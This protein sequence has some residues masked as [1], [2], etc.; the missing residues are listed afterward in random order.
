MAA[1]EACPSPKPSYRPQEVATTFVEGYYLLLRD[2]PEELHKFYLD[3][4]TVS[5]RVG[6]DGGAMTNFTTMEEIEKQVNTSLDCKEYEIVSFYAQIAPNK[7]VFV[8]VVGC[9]T[10]KDDKMRKFNQSFLLAPME[11]IGYFVSNDILSFLDEQ[12]TIT[13][14]IKDVPKDCSEKDVPKDVPKKS[15]L[16]VVSALTENNDPFKAPPVKKSV[17]PTPQA[18][19]PERK[20]GLDGKKKARNVV[21]NVKGERSV[22]VGNLAF[23]SNPEEV[24]EA[25]KSSFGAIKQN[26]VQIRTDKLNRCYAFIQFESSESA[27]SAVQASSIRIGNRKLNI[28]EKKRNA[29]ENHKSSQDQSINGNVSAN[30]Q[31]NSRGNRN[32][33]RRNGPEN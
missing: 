29:S 10:T 23:D 20:S 9:L 19:N 30:G 24:Y 6:S 32:S 3:S 12:E 5:R 4:S 27:K 28:E 13:I 25:F 11:G 33:N 15:F 26:G 2:H 22:F 17:R 21:E 14:D 7:G 1:E 8:M 31:T 18:A 16:S